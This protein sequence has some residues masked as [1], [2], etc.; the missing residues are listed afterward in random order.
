[1]WKTPGSSRTATLHNY[2]TNMFR[3]FTGQQ[4]QEQEFDFI[5]IFAEH[6]SYVHIDVKAAMKKADGWVEQLERGEEF[7]GYIG[8]AEFKGWQFIPVV[9]FP[10][11]AKQSQVNETV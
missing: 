8:A 5:I 10:N 6:K 2:N 11:A 7:I 3:L 4:K 9:A 1:M